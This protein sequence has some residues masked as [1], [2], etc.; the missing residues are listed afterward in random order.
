[1]KHTN[2]CFI[3]LQ[4]HFI[5]CVFYTNFPQM[6]PDIFGNFGK[7]LW[8]WT[9]FGSQADCNVC[10]VCL[11]PCVSLCDSLFRFFL[12]KSRGKWWSLEIPV[13]NGAC[14]KHVPTDY[15]CRWSPFII[16][17]VKYHC[18]MCSTN[19]HLTLPEDKITLEEQIVYF[20]LFWLWHNMVFISLHCHKGSAMQCN[21]L[22][23][24]FRV[25]Q[26]TFCAG[27]MEMW[28]SQFVSNPRAYWCFLFEMPGYSL[29]SI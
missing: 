7:V 3:L 5:M 25:L 11:L 8:V 21:Q 19:S 22:R 15:Y 16:I 4:H 23:V 14:L 2:P 12:N 26:K 24:S 13:K 1:M 10:P 29:R 28:K 18:V 9:M 27:Y 17:A 6:L 20:L